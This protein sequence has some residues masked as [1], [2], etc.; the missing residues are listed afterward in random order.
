MLKERSPIFNMQNIMLSVS[1]MSQCPKL[2]VVNI[3]GVVVQ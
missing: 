3:Q 1:K 2:I